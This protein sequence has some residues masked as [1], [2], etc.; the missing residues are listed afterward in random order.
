VLA[1]SA[2]S[3]EILAQAG[4]ADADLFIA[5]TRSDE[6]NMPECLMAARLDSR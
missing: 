3:R 2:T 1:G 4:A 5:V 6:V